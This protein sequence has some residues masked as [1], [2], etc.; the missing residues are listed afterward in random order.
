MPLTGNHSVQFDAAT[1]IAYDLVAQGD[2][3]VPDLS[4]QVILDGYYTLPNGTNYTLEVG[5]LAL[6]A[7]G[8]N[9]TYPQAGTNILFNASLI[10]GYLYETGQVPSNS[11]GFHIGSAALGILLLESLFQS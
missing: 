1:I 2:A 7:E 3:K 5:A 6:G 9:Q 4:L 10:S 8:I 11:Y